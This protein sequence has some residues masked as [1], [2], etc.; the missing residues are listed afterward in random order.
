MDTKTWKDRHKYNLLDAK[1]NVLLNSKAEVSVLREV[2]SSQLILLH[3]QPT[4][5]D[6]LSLIERN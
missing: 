1:I 4:L 3:L 6:L 2:L 5:Q